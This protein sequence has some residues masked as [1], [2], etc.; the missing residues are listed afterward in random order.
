[1]AIT[2]KLALQGEIQRKYPDLLRRYTRELCTFC[3]FAGL[4]REGCGQGLLPV[5]ING[6]KCLYFVSCKAAR[7]DPRLALIGRR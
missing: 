6:D 3:H 1:M 5:T 7:R 2:T 4:G